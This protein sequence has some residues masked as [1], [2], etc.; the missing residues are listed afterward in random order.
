MNKPHTKLH[1]YVSIRKNKQPTHIQERLKS[2]PQCQNL[3]A[4]IKKNPVADVIWYISSR[5]K[6]YS[7]QVEHQKNHFI[8]DRMQ[9]SYMVGRLVAQKRTFHRN[10]NFSAAHHNRDSQ[11]VCVNS[12]MLLKTSRWVRSHTRL[13]VFH[14]QDV[15]PV[16]YHR[17]FFKV[18]GKKIDY[19][20]IFFAFSS[21]CAPAGLGSHMRRHLWP[22][23]CYLWLRFEWN[24]FSH[25]FLIT[26]S[27]K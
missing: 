16:F 7:W 10:G 22:D 13:E 17:M 15:T 21:S 25:R 6:Y 12:T 8:A 19:V 2:R 5:L 24:L 18:R 11:C 20:S 9:L 14:P 26:Y 27:S 1:T 23:R 4:S 3:S